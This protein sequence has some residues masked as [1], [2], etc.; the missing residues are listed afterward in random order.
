MTSTTPEVWAGPECA[1]LRVGD[2]ACDQLALTGH[3]RRIEDLNRLA[4]LGIKAVRY[5]V[6]WGRTSR[7]DEPTD[8]AWATARLERLAALGVRP[9]VGLLHHG[10]GPAEHDPLD[11]R[12]PSAFGRYAGEVARRF[13]TATAFLPV[14]EPLTTA[15]FGGLYGWWPPYGRDHGTFVR[16]LLAQAEAYLEAARAIRSVRPGVQILVNEDLGRT[17]SSAACRRAADRDNERRW[18]SFDLVSGRVDPGHALWRALADTPRERRI[19]DAL[20][21][22]PEVP[23]VLGVDYYV[24]SD[25]YLDERLDAFPAATHGGDGR[26][27]YA[28]VELARVGGLEIAGFG[29]AIR[30]TWARYGRPVA[31]TEVHLAGEAPDQVA[32]WNEAVDAAA[33]S[34]AD[35]IPVAGVTAWS[36]FGAYEWSSILRD[37]CGS[38]AS[39]C[40][41]VRADGTPR[42]TP[43]GHAVAASALGQSFVTRPGWWRRRD[44]A[45]YELNRNDEVAA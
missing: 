42:R 29:A 7:A 10:F 26:Q 6:L 24:T 37:P 8:W 16:L 13:P 30:D 41:D 17:A 33:G 31:L 9:I 19:L 14:N 32:W 1:W 2:W 27:A 39:G 5:P 43:F 34:L 45:I 23:D 21:R 12:W 28:D 40:F 11:P 18:L 22:E 38:Y 15:R 44:R 20:R 25:R 35:G 4:G 36:A 3:D